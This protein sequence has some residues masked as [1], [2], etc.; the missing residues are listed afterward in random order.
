M[1]RYF[2]GAKKLSSMT[3]IWT[4]L[5][6][7]LCSRLLIVFVL[8]IGTQTELQPTEAKE[9]L[10]YHPRFSSSSESAQKS[11]KQVLLSADGYW[12]LELADKG[13][14]PGQVPA[15]K[16]KNWTFFP[17]YP[18]LINLSAYLTGRPLLSS[19]ILNNLCFLLSLVLL[20]KLILRLS[21]NHSQA[22][23]SVWLLALFPTSY[24]YSTPLT[25]SLFLCLLLSSFLALE[26]KYILCSGLIFGLLTAT[27]VTG[28][29]LL[30]AYFFRLWEKGSLNSLR[31]LLALALAPT[32]LIIFMFFLHEQTGSAFAFLENQIHWGRTTASLA[33]F[34]QALSSL[35]QGLIQP[36]NF[37][38]LNLLVGLLALISGILFC[39]QKQYSWGLMLLVPLTASLSTGTFQSLSRILMVLFPIYLVLGGCH[40][41]RWLQTALIA[42]SASLLSLMTLA[43]ALHITAAMA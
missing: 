33:G 27:R 36:W 7:F 5:K 31:G 6:V 41:P 8:L 12:Y 14:D 28:I 21:S 18:L 32:G 24:F 10:N 9:G 34:K 2:K 23:L 11:L 39:L 29:L 20:Y 3:D 37:L 35:G 43:Y 25:E 1:N 4:P 30:P 16:A 17:L 19:L 40:N 26:N 22:E 15:K 38:G 13:Y 42:I